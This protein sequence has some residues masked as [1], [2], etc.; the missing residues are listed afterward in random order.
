MQAS[1][2]R[3]TINAIPSPSARGQS[4]QGQ[5]EAYTELS[6]RDWALGDVRR[7]PFG[8]RCAFSGR[9]W[10]SSPTPGGPRRRPAGAARSLVRCSDAP[11]RQNTSHLDWVASLMGRPCLRAIYSS[12]PGLPRPGTSAHPFSPAAT[13]GGGQPGKAGGGS[14]IA[15][16]ALPACLSD[17]GISRLFGL[18]D[19]AS[20]PST[21]ALIDGEKG[22][23]LRRRTTGAPPLPVT[24]PSDGHL[25]RAAARHLLFG[26][27]VATCSE[28]ATPGSPAWLVWQRAGDD[29]GVTSA[30]RRAASAAAG[31]ATW[32]AAR[33]LGAGRHA[34]AACTC[35]PGE[36]FRPHPNPESLIGC[37]GPAHAHAR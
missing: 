13:A 25:K 12:C 24:S 8:R 21:A 26:G 19:R 28:A 15:E 1:L 10:D 3:R 23:R 35:V 17:H 4:L 37:R 33:P 14:V 36:W 29:A 18:G 30:G 16:G 32:A 2:S 31:A 34:A 9:D 22:C 11:P 5:L 27:H 6:S 20:P 7:H